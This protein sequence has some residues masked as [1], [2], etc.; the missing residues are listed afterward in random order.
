MCNSKDRQDGV[1]ERGFLRL[2]FIRKVRRQK[3]VHLVQHFF[4]VLARLRFSEQVALA[5]FAAEISQDRKLALGLD[6][7]GDDAHLEVFRERNY[8]LQHL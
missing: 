5:V 2:V 6:A 8:R 4:R 3:A 1:L 7:L